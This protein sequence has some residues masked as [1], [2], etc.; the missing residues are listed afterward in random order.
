MNNHEDF[1]RAE[2]LEASS[3][4]SF[5]LV[6][7]IFALLIAVIPALRGREP[8]WWALAVAGVCLAIALIRPAL[9]H[10]AN[11]VWTRLA[12]ILNR[13]VS[14]IVTALLFYVVF[15]PAGFLVRLG[16]KDPLRLR[17]EGH[18]KSYWRER[19]PPGPPPQSMAQQF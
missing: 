16:E 9:L 18:T 14:P 7:A 10:H 4:R 15:T 8:R 3:D 5:S 12:V 6:F 19:Q 13:V 11:I 17:F 2:A 1:S